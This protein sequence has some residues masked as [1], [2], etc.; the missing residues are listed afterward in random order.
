ML[1]PEPNLVPEHSQHQPGN[2]TASDNPVFLQ[3]EHPHRRFNP[4]SQDW[5]LVSPHR[6][7]RPWQGQLEDAG[8]Q[9]LPAYDP[10]CYLCAGNVRI[11]GERNPNYRT[12]YVFTNDF[13][14]LRP[15]GPLYQHN[16]DNLFVLQSVQGT[17]RVIC[18]SD[19][20]SKTLP[21]LSQLQIVQLIRSWIN[22]YQQ[23][24][25]HYSWVQVFENKGAINGCSNP[26]P[27][28]QIW[29]SNFIP[30]L[31][32][33]ADQAQRQYQQ[34]YGKNLLLHYANTEL[35]KAERLV[36]HNEHWLVVVPYWASWPFETLLLPLSQVA[37]MEQLNHAQQ[38]A[39]ADIL[40][41][42][43]IRYDNLFQCAFPYSMGWHCAPYCSDPQQDQQ[44]CQYWQL[45]AH[46]YPPLLRSASIKKFMVG[47]EMLAEAQRD[48][49]PE[50]AALL[51]RNQSD[52]HY[53]KQQAAPQ[54]AAA[55]HTG[56]H[57]D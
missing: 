44:S 43:T 18:Y 27:H 28:G 51:L 25:A 3:T 55:Q 11:S 42:L 17:S 37:R 9:D 12:P 14:A 57:H 31:P 48:M 6:A 32:A 33:K 29:A 24:S 22:Q 23:L 54:Q 39:L 19:D 47:Y 50:Q 13:A 2:T 56:T 21:E 38:L 4:L 45:H 30:T 16:D 1:K 10:D 34:Q 46:F 26:H 52:I 7:K 49:T 20:H 35:L 36:I 40:Q 41:R 8:Q 15:D 53:K 5:V